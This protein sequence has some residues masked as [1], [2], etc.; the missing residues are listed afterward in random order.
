[1]I[2]GVH[3]WKVINQKNLLDPR[4]LPMR[5]WSYPNKGYLTKEGLR[6]RILQR[7]LPAML[8]EDKFWD[9]TRR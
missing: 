7:E 9:K 1:M 4:L 2:C 5:M 3:G 6:G 8:A